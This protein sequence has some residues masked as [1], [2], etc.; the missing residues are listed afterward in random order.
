MAN[1]FSKAGF[2]IP[3]LSEKSYNQILTKFNL[4]GSTYTN[5]IEGR[6]LANEDHLNNV[7]DVLNED[8]NVD[9]IV[10]EIHISNRNDKLSVY[11]GHT[12]EIFS[13][14]KNAQKNLM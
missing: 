8:S 6:T 5:P 9:I 12:P 3:R 11:R 10:H 2:S 7:L 1:V 13:N 4:V 14:L